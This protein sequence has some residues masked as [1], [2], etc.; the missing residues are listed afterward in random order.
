MSHLGHRSTISVVLE[1]CY[2]E[3]RSLCEMLQKN[4]KFLAIYRSNLWAVEL[5]MYY[6]VDPRYNDTVCYR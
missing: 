1:I 4:G 6:T 3:L 5:G 2:L